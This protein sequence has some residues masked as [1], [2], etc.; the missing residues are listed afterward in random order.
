MQ[1]DDQKHKYIN[2]FSNS[3]EHKNEEKGKEID[4]LP[5]DIMGHVTTFLPPSHLTNIISS[6]KDARKFINSINNVK[7][8]KMVQT[9][10]KLFESLNDR[11]RIGIDEN[12]EKYQNEMNLVINMLNNDHHHY[13][14]FVTKLLLS[15]IDSIDSPLY[16]IFKIMLQTPNWEI[17]V[18]DRINFLLDMYY[19]MWKKDIVSYICGFDDDDQVKKIVVA[20]Q[21]DYENEITELID[22]GILKNFTHRDILNI[23]LEL[24]GRTKFNHNHGNDNFE[25]RLIQYLMN[26]YIV[27]KNDLNTI[28][29]FIYNY[30]MDELMNQFNVN[31]YPG[32]SDYEYMIEIIKEL[33]SVLQSLVDFEFQITTTSASLPRRWIEP[34]SFAPGDPY[35]SNDVH[36]DKNAMM[37][38][39]YG[40]KDIL[41]MISN[42]VE[43]DVNIWDDRNIYDTLFTNILNSSFKLIPDLRKNWR[44]WISQ[45]EDEHFYLLKHLNKFQALFPHTFE[46]LDY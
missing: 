14:Q 39:I 31:H 16:T 37:E 17:N 44:D 9:Y 42:L 3:L 25:H 8:V 24:L 12:D 19:S 11:F 15:L 20:I 28:S 13:S 21:K 26:L 33:N 2:P 29:M 35:Y 38:P 1:N 34:N 40:F 30:F 32:E 6:S 36:E 43:D 18:V 22:L 27:D 5:Y 41:R 23:I 45:F 10:R 46:L 7:D 4:G